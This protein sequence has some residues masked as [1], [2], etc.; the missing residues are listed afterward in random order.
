[1]DQWVFTDRWR[2]Q[3]SSAQVEAANDV[4]ELGVP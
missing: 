4:T 3:Y 1:M 2:R